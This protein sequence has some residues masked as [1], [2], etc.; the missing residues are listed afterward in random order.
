MTLAQIRFDGKFLTSARAARYHAENHSLP[1][2][3]IIEVYKAIDPDYSD[4]RDAIHAIR[5]QRSD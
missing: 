4:L 2:K 3:E 1:V 5:S